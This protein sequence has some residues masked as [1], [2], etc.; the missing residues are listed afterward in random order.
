M[1]TPHL[2]RDRQLSLEN[3]RHLSKVTRQRKQVTD[4]EI[5]ARLVARAAHVLAARRAAQRIGLASDC[6]PQ[7][8]EQPLVGDA[9]RLG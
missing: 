1:A 6:R 9:C 8:L 4:G 5:L 7:L 3:R 2:H